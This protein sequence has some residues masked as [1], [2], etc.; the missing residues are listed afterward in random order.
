[1]EGYGVDFP[2]EEYVAIKEAMESAQGKCILSIN[3]H[4]AIRELF[5]DFRRESAQIKYTV[6]GSKPGQVRQASE[7]ILYNW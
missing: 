1:M 4:P 5:T 2:W 7:L 6:G 3:D